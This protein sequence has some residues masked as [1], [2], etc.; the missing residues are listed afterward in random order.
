M[1]LQG[2]EKPF[3]GSNVTVGIVTSQ[4]IF[5]LQCN[6]LAVACRF[7][8]C[9]KKDVSFLW[10]FAHGQYLNPAEILTAVSFNS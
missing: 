8:F 2:T 1:T 4:C 5:T 10:V 7:F 6:S 3:F 9:E